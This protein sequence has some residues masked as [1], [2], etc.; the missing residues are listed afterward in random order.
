MNF[1]IFILLIFSSIS[2]FAQDIIEYNGE[3]IN[4]LDANGKQTGIWKLFDEAQDIL[5][6]TEFQEGQ[7]IS[8]TKYF[9]NSQLFASYKGKDELEIYKDGKTV[10]AY[11]S[12]K[13]DGSQT[14][15]D[16]NKIQLEP[17]IL[18]YFYLFGEVKPIFYG[19]TSQLYDFIGKTID[20][21]AVKSNKGRVKVKF[22]IDKVGWPTELQIVESSNPE[23]NNEA[24]R[25]VSTLPRWQPGHQAGSFVKVSY[26]IPINIK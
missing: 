11:F 6:T 19:G 3:K 7:I 22:V 23:L 8:D 26:V 17:E 21:K 1:K 20:Y 18:R 25:I 24:L 15:V 10:L 5:I 12:R 13:P 14:L 4:A 2:G 16:S 9:K